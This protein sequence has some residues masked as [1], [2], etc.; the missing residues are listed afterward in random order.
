MAKTTKSAFVMKK[1]KD[2]NV[3]EEAEA[4][5][6]RLFASHPGRNVRRPLFRKRAAE[7][8]LCTR[9]KKNSTNGDLCLCT[10]CLKDVD[11]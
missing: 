10:A 11:P 7:P 2:P 9:C 6:D 1:L 3:D 8:H 4:A 5:C